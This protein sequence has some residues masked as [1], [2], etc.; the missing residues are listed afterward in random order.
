MWSH[1]EVVK[2]IGRY[3]LGAKDKGFV[4]RPDLKKSFECFVDA[5]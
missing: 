2:R 1:G 5:D 3:L 4:V